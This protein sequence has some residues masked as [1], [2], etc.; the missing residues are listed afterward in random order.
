M[1]YSVLKLADQVFWR[2]E[3]SLVHSSIS[4]IGTRTHKHSDILLFR[5]DTPPTLPPTPGPSSYDTAYSKHGAPLLR[6]SL[7]TPLTPVGPSDIVSA[8]I[9][10]IL[11]DS[12]TNIRS[13]TMT[14]ERRIQLFSPS[15]ISQSSSTSSS[16]PITPLSASKTFFTTSITASSSNPLTNTDAAYASTTHLLPHSEIPTVRTMKTAI[17]D[18]VSSTS[19]MKQADGTLTKTLTLPWPSARTNSRWSI[20]ETVNSSELVSVRFYAHVK[21]RLKTDSDCVGHHLKLID[22]CRYHHLRETTQSSYQN[23]RSL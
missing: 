11:A 3:A 1:I 4:G 12:N 9:T 14:I 22:S 6:Y 8:P 10:L 2:I 19:F 7:R 15:S 21:V 23:G 16:I 18:A 17:A 13:S 5:H 20:G